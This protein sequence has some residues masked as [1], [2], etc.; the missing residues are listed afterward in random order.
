[1]DATAYQRVLPPLGVAVTIL[2][3]VDHMGVVYRTAAI[4]A[5][6]AAVRETGW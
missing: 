1:M 4:R 5:T 2:P 6:V 3:G